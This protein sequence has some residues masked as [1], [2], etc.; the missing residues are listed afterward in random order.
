MP[1]AIHPFAAWARRSSSFLAEL[2][3]KDQQPESAADLLI[4]RLKRWPKL[5]S[6]SMSTDIYRTLSVMSTRPVNRRWILNNSSLQADQLDLLLHRLIEQDAL[7]VTDAAKYRP[8]THRGL[9][10]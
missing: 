4:Y 2:F 7:D 3:R 6:S 10:A 9:N 8:D 1:S 5:P